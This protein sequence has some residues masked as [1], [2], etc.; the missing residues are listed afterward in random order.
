MSR[1]KGGYKL[2][3]GTKVPGVTT[4]IGKLKDAG[5]LMYWAWQQGV[6]GKDFRETRD[7]AASAGTVVHAMVENYL[8]GTVPETALNGVGAEI[9]SKASS[10]YLGFLE[11]A[12]QTK[13]RVIEPELSL[14]SET[15]RV[16][17][18]M[19]CSVLS[20]NDRLAIGD[21]KSSN[22]LYAEMLVQV[23]TYGMLYEERFPDRPITGGYHIMRFSKDHGDFHH[24]YFTELAGARRA[25]VLLRELYDLDKELKVRAK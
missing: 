14:V 1:P 23:A 8:R 21:W 2:A 6:E 13:L 11:W 9:A 16:G 7:A 4:V 18:T 5:P 12:E 25:F 17:G 10:A 22:G 20:I 24:H 19:D 15:L 3:D